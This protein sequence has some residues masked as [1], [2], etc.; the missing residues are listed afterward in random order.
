[1]TG[2]PNN[3][4]WSRIKKLLGNG[5]HGNGEAAQLLDRDVFGMAMRRERSRADRAGTPVSLVTVSGLQSKG[6][7]NDAARREKLIANLGEILGDMIR[8]T[9]IAGWFDA[10]TVGLILPHTA[11]KDAWNLVERVQAEL[12]RRLKE[13][14]AGNGVSFRVHTY[15]FQEAAPGTKYRQ[16]PLFDRRRRFR[17]E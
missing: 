2:S 3:S 11:G 6:N 1:M 15:P 8:C 5:E 12:D 16:M 13:A 4:I 10:G 17:A 14:V 9:D 7:D